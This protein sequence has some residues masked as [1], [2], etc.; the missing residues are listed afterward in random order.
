MPHWVPDSE[1]KKLYDLPDRMPD[2]TYQI[3][4]EDNTV[5]V[6][7]QLEDPRFAEVLGRSSSFP[8]GFR[9]I[10]HIEGQPENYKV[11]YR[12]NLLEVIVPKAGK[13][14]DISIE[15]KVH[16]AKLKG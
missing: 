16:Y 7:T 12:D 3:T 10:F 8:N 11:A 15:Q 13:V 2:Y 6:E 14:E 9:N 5:I 4:L 1:Y